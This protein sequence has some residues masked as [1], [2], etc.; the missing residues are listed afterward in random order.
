[1]SPLFDLVVMQ[2]SVSTDGQFCFKYYSTAAV[3]ET[4][5]SNCI[6]WGGVESSLYI[7]STVSIGTRIIEIRRWHKQNPHKSS[8]LSSLH[9][10]TLSV[11]TRPA[12]AIWRPPRSKRI[13]HYSLHCVSFLVP[14]STFQ[15]HLFGSCGP[16]STFQPHLFGSCVLWN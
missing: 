5:N 2:S 14:L 9:R 15:P 8:L 3:M 4:A 10:L 12:L 11:C 1:M 7:S 16:L 13:A 6:V